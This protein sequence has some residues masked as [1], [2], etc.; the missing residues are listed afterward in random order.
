MIDIKSSNFDIWAAGFF[1]GE[2]CVLVARCKNNGV[3]GG[4]N[5]YLQVSIAQQDR[6]PLELINSKFGGAIR[7]NRGKATYEKKKEHVYTWSLVLSGTNAY[8]FL[9]A[10]QPYCVVKF[11]QVT[12]ALRWPIND[13]KQYRG[14]WNAMPEEE[15]SLR[16]EIRDN[17]ISL[18]ESVKV[19][20]NV[21]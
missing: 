18:R 17:L 13:G 20:A 3:R 10:I 1:D 8:S 21:S 15:R 14:S 7:L 12:E 11:E 6:R 5:Y 4:W 19:Y 2:G 16:A 9:K